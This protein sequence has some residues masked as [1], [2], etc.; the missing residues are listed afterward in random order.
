MRRPDRRG[1]RRA[2]HTPS[3]SQAPIVVEPV[4]VYICRNT[5]GGVTV[6]APSEYFRLRA[7]GEP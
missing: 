7:A 4:G 3:L 1:S 2:G 5:L 6:L